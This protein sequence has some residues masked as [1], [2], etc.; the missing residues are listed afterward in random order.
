MKKILVINAN[1]KVSSFCQAMAERYVAKARETS[2]VQLVHLST[3]HFELDLHQGYDQTPPL[4]QDLLNFQQQLQWAQHIVLVCP[5][6]WGGMPA[7]LKGLF[8][9]VLLPGFAFK[10]QPGKLTLD[11]PVF[12]YRWWQGQPLH[13]QLKKTIL[14][15][16]GIRNQ[17]THYFGPVISADAAKRER[18]LDKVSQLAG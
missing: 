6:W 2:Q 14:D 10:Y 18:W 4:E 8:D 3:L 9:R 13:Y 11:T 7:K 5:V 17:A 12:W 1:P 16:V 15:F